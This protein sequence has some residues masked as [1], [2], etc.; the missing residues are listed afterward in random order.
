VGEDGIC[1]LDYTSMQQLSKH[2][3]DSIVT[4]GGC[5]DDFM[6]VLTT[7]GVCAAADDRQATVKLLFHTRKSEV[8]GNNFADVED[9]LHA[10][11]LWLQILAITLLIADYMNMI[12][13]MTPGLLTAPAT[14]NLSSLGRCSNAMRGSSSTFSAP[15]LRTGNLAMQGDSSRPLLKK[16]RQLDSGVA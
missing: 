7:D 12:G 4:F 10:Q 3:Y 1:T 15:L 14:P 6:L 9:S 2:P 11:L 5:Q 16:R 13:R 8:S